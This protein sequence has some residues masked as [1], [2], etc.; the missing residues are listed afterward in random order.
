MS[1]NDMSI[2]NQGG[3]AFRADLNAALQAQASNQSGSTEPSTMYPYQ[4]WAD[5]T[6]G[7]LKIRNGANTAWVTLLRLNGL[8]PNL[9]IGGGTYTGN[10]LLSVSATLQGDGGTT[11]Y[12][13][14]NE[15]IFNTTAAVSSIHNQTTI[16]RL[17]SAANHNLGTWVGHYCELR[18][19]SGHSAI[20]T[21]ANAFRAN[22]ILTAGSVTNYE[23]F[24]VD[25]GVS[26]TSFTAAFRGAVTSGAGKYNVYMDGTAPNYLNGVLNIGSVQ[27]AAK[28]SVYTDS[29]EAIRATTNSIN[30]YFIIDQA[31]SNTSTRPTLSMRK[32]NTTRWQVS[33]DGLTAN[34]GATYIEAIGTAGKHEFF[35]G[36]V[37]RWSCS[38]SGHWVPSSDNVYDIGVSGSLR[39]RN[40]YSPSPISNS[41]ARLKTEITDSVLGLDFINSLRPVSYKF[42]VGE[43]RVDVHPDDLDKPAG[44]RREIVTA[45]QGKRRHFGLIAQDV[46]A[47]VP[48]DIDFGGWCLGDKDDPDST[49]AL[50]YSEF[51]CPLIKAVQELSARVVA[52]EH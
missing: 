10:T 52:L 25:A 23:G 35:T 14:F 45:V 16:T 12:G 32:S 4:L 44:N 51:I 3:A 31:D 39:V 13:V 47:A 27:A 38:N 50:I 37:A 21:N 9:Q 8:F 49:Q 17:T 19:E 36:G 11:L 42:I 15:N 18:K 29:L 20:I 34:S 2:A 6:A 41:D 26:G 33:S 43:N 46:K 1:Q 28:L 22:A 24:T 30:C 7:M 48:S 5:T 40:I